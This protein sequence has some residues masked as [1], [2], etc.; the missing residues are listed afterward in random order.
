MGISVFFNALIHGSISDL[1][2]VRE[3]TG[4]VFVKKDLVRNV[5]TYKF[6]V[7]ARD[8]RG[9]GFPANASVTVIVKPSSN[10]PPEWVIPPID[11]MTIYVLEV[12][13]EWC[14]QKN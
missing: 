13:K 10:S 7:Q 3:Q 14:Q 9:A 4:K 6:N 2:D 12:R 11:N 5:G 1:F 8:L